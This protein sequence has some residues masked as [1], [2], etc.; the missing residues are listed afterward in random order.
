MPLETYLPRPEEEYGPDAQFLPEGYA[1]SDPGDAG[2]GPADAPT[3]APTPT[4]GAAPAPASASPEKPKT[5]EKLKTLEK[6]KA[7]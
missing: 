1:R 7:D 3:T 4:E 6:P 5:P 2:A